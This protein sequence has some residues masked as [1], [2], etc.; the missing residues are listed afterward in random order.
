MCWQLMATVVLCISCRWSQRQRWKPF[1]SA[2]ERPMLNFVPWQIN[3]NATLK[4]PKKSELP[5]RS[6]IS[7]VAKDYKEEFRERIS[8]KK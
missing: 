5:E 8:L 4:I 2:Q 7:T 6:K 1:G 3:S